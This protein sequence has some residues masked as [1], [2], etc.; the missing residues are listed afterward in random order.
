MINQSKLILIGTIS[1]PSGIRGDLVVKSF[2]SPVTNIGKI[3][4]VNQAMEEIKLT[5]IRQNAN[6]DLICGINNVS[7][8][9]DAEL[10]RGHKLFCLRSSLPDAG[11]DEF[12][13]EDLKNLLV[14]NDNLITIGEVVGVHN[15]GA[16]EII[17]I[18]FHEGKAE[19]FP[20]TKEFFPIITNDYI[21]FTQLGS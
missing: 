13:I 5:I 11:E 18:K 19:L 9:N 7:T 12:Y 17:E 21:I 16:G 1:S 4:I 15:F 8:R 10:L 20:F 14:V 2:T 6:G 3:A